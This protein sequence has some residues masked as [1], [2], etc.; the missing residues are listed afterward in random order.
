MLQWVTP[1]ETPMPILQTLL[2]L[3]PSILSRG[4]RGRLAALRAAW[5]K[6]VARE[7]DM[8]LIATLHDLKEGAGPTVDELTWRDLALDDV[9]A[10]V[11]RTMGMPGRQ[12]LYHQMRTY[13]DRDEVLAE[14]ARQYEVLRGASGF[15]EEAQ[16]ILAALDGPSAFYLAPLLHSQL[17]DRPWFTPL[18]WLCSLAGIVTVGGAIGGMLFFPPLAVPCLLAALAVVAI[19]IAV[20]ETYGRKVT[21]FL[22]GIHQVAALLGVSLRLARAAQA[23]DLPQVAA[24]RA[25]APLAARLSRS[26]FLLVKDRV[27]MGD[28]GRSFLGYMNMILLADILAFLASLRRLKQHRKELLEL[29]EAVATLDAALSVASYLEGLPA[30]TTPVLGPGRGFRVRGL[31]HPLLAHPVAND[32]D[33]DGASALITGSNMTGKTTFMRTVGVNLI[34]ARTLNICLAREARFPRAIVASSIRREDSQEEGKSYYFTELE[35]I[36]TFLKGAGDLR[37]FLIDEIFRGT[38]TLERLASSA[39]VLRH[40]AKE[41]LVFVTSHDLEL[42]ELLEQGY[43]TF[44]FSERV[45]DGTCAFDYLIHGGPTRSRNAI[46]L[47]ELVGYPADVTEQAHAFADRIASAD[48]PSGTQ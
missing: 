34:L 5:G 27:R 18:L 3:C 21:P 32:L 43:A 33:L 41:D 2:N 8:M 13:E 28:I 44:H 7:R 39:A 1:I 14:R 11:D 17:P 25:M 10:A 36:L 38:N 31:Y 46:R 47:L 6:P 22:P 35:R 23:P 45:H 30:A 40:L 48:L 16:R 12:W 29:L 15:R 19:N 9:F 37:L 20:N 24:C 42:Q 26:L 4:R